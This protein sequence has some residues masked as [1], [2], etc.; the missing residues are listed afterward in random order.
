[1]LNNTLHSIP[2]CN[3]CGS[4]LVL[5]KTTT[6]KS[7]HSFASM[8]QNSYRC[9]NKSCQDEI[10]KRSIK[11]MELKKEQELAREKRLNKKV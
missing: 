7:E 4:D 2:K 9:S 6:Q 10:D 11:R 3:Q 1:V 5:Q 8:T